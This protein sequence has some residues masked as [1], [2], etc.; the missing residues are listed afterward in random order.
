MYNKLEALREKGAAE[1]M[2]LSNDYV[3]ARDKLLKAKQ[4]FPSLDHIVPMLTVCD[5]LLASKSR[6]P[7][8][9]TDHYWVLQLL[10]SSTLSD[11]QYQHHKLVTLLEP[12]KNKFPRTVLALEIIREAFSVLSDRRKRLT[13]DSERGSSWADYE[14][15]QQASSERGSFC[16]N[17]DG[18][19]RV[20]LST[21]MNLERVRNF[22]PM[23][24]ANEN[25]TKHVNLSRQESSSFSSD[26][27][28]EDQTGEDRSSLVDDMNS[29]EDMNRHTS[30]KG[31]PTWSSKA[32]VKE[33]LDQDFYNFENNR[34][35]ECIGTG[36]I[37]AVHHHLDEPQNCRYAQINSVS[38]SAIGVTWLKPDPVTENERRWCD[39]GLPVA[40][41]SFSIDLE[42]SGQAS[43]VFSYN[44][45]LVPGV[46]A[47][48]FEIY[49]IKGEVWA[50]YEDWSLDEWSCNPELVN[51]C[52]YKLV[53][54]LDSSKYFGIEG[55]CLVKVDGSKSIYQRE[56][57]EGNP[58]IFHISLRNLY[59]L[60]HKVPSYRFS[61]EE[62]GGFENGMFELDQLALQNGIRQ[63]M[64][65]QMTLN[66]ENSDH[67]NFTYNLEQLTS[68]KPNVEG[69]MLGSNW[70]PNDFLTGQVWAVYCGKDMMPRQYAR[71]N[72][73]IAGD[74]VCV[75][76]LEPQPDFDFDANW[77]KENVHIVCGLFC[78]NETAV[79]LEIS[80]LSHSVKCQQSTT[81]PVYKI[82][83]K[84]GEVW[85]M[86][87][88]GNSGDEN[89]KYYIVEILSDFSGER[90]SIAKLEEV[91]GCLTFFQRQQSDGF[92]LAREV[93][94]TDMLSFSHQIPAFRVPGIKI[95]G[96]PESSWHLEPNALPPIHGM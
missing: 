22:G 64:N 82:Y 23:L 1:K 70:S 51:G 87:Q 60:S 96:I 61:G 32:V 55:A 66:D 92:D 44:C 47:E 11:I 81:R 90:M 6:V 48:Q 34:S 65:S 28:I 42:V 50:V 21:V 95:H 59:M 83:P 20:G 88:K 62:I 29:P 80:R 75:T 94:K 53:E 8:Y 31:P 56:T 12:I 26:V 63:D 36:Q 49:P 52:K 27:N 19:N 18:R 7:G 76:F 68:V 35:A 84:K 67:S 17:L 46:T 40:C 77:K 93:S 72:N 2:I 54:I 38:Q 74:Q 39:A 13:F 9:D 4:L 41:G 43:T 73:V 71:I 25:T 58:I 91:R 45:T 85:A 3:S 14:L 30:L 79:N 78:A 10:P 16:Q 24:R 86:Y 33:M 89:H 5:T 57:I 37:W 69:M 15:S